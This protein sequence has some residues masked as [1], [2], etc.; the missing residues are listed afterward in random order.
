MVFDYFIESDKCD[1]SIE[2]L[3]SAKQQFLGAVE[4]EALSPLSSFKKAISTTAIAQQ[5]D[6]LYASH[7]G[8][9]YYIINI[10]PIS[11]SD[12][13]I[14]DVLRAEVMEAGRRRKVQEIKSLM[15][16]DKMVETSGGPATEA[17]QV[18]DGVGQGHE[19]E[20]EQSEIPENLE[21]VGNIN[22][23]TQLS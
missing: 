17:L 3:R 10:L 20:V 12:N 8:I 14:S 4:H 16:K 15:A 2:Q 23:E 11:R 22:D 5:M 18:A 6:T 7:G 9:N 19:G 1:E 13:P 21:K